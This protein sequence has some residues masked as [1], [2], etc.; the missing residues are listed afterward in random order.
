MKLTNRDGSVIEVQLDSDQSIEFNTEGSQY[1]MLQPYQVSG[2]ATTIQQN[3]L[4][5]VSTLSLG[6]I[7]RDIDKDE[8]ADYGL[9]HPAKL[10]MTDT[11]GNE[12]HLLIGDVCPN[13]DY[14]LLYAG[15]DGSP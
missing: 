4:D 14:N 10:E 9:D 1:V 2:N 7:I 3:I 6:S 8:Y 5:V 15:G 13:A 12:V 11:S